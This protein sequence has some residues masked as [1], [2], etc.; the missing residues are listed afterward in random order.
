[1]RNLLLVLIIFIAGIL[2]L[3]SI[4]K[5]PSSL[6]WDEV[7]FGY[8]AYSIGIDGRDEFGRFL[9]FDYFESFGDF[10]PPVYVYLTVI[11]VRILGLNEFAVRLPN[12]FFGILTVL[13]TYFLV[14]EVFY[15]SK[16]KEQYAITSAALLAIS[17]W[18]V[19]L[20][21][22]AFEANIATFFIICGVWLFLLG[23]KKNMWILVLSAISFVLS[24]YTFNTA[25][26]VSPLLV[27]ILTLTNIDRLL[28]NKRQ[29]IFAALVGLLTLL[30]SVPFLFS[31]QARLRFNEV[32]IFSDIR[33]IEKANS[34]VARDGNLWWSKIIHNRRFAYS[35]EFLKHYFDNFSTQFL[36]IKGDGNPKFSTQ[37]VGQ[38][39]LWELPFLVIGILWLIRNKEGR[40]WLIPVWLLVGMIPAAV[41]RETPHALRIETTLPTFQIIT[42]YGLVMV[43]SY[44]RYSTFNEKIKKISL[45]L[46]TSI[47]FSNFLYYINGYFNYYAKEYSGEW[48]HGYKES[49]SFVNKEYGKYN[50]F[51]ITEDLGRP[52]IYYLFYGNFEPTKFRQN[53]IVK[54]EVLGF[55]HVEKFDK[56]YFAKDIMD[57]PTV[58]SEDIL[59][60]DIPKKVPPNANIIKTFYLLNGKVSLVAFTI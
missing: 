24:M 55:V 7:A 12:A 51:Y 1:M 48:Q 14:K 39:Y 36:F 38:M 50:G 57:I 35:V 42:A 37:D 13:I 58:E 43:F 54:R 16:H 21:R 59:Y 46:F 17:P 45:V 60:I 15:S 56:F 33:V 5:I 44:L 26:I 31:P 9:P 47:V 32:N 28:K 49:V 2:R 53:S 4:D 19:N 8:N 41:A 6:T 10:K 3:V 30:P 25:R 11:P 27:I 29:V 20:S 52:Y 34:Q 22:A 40:W 18:H 23:I